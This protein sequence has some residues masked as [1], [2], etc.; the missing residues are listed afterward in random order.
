MPHIFMCGQST[1]YKSKTHTVIIPIS[2]GIKFW[3]YG[4]FAFTRK[5]ECLMGGAPS[6]LVCL[7]GQCGCT[8]CMMSVNQLLC[9]RPLIGTNHPEI[10]PIIPFRWLLVILEG[11][12]GCASQ[13]MS[14]VCCCFCNEPPPAPWARTKN[15]KGCFVLCEKRIKACA[16]KIMAPR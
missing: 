7:K 12:R 4:C 1:R 9:K 15:Q 8:S 11:E 3:I 10:G 6:N 14:S 16:V 5:I 13:R 2:L